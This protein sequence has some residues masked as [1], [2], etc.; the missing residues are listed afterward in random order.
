M[1]PISQAQKTFLNLYST[2]NIKE[3]SFQECIKFKPRN[4]IKL[5]HEE[6][7]CFKRKYNCFTKTGRLSYYN[8]ALFFKKKQHENTTSNK[9]NKFIYLYIKVRITSTFKSMTKSNLLRMF[10]ITTYFQF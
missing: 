9:I 8:I 10:T 1:R 2:Q 3:N 4:R 6:C 5:T 7:L